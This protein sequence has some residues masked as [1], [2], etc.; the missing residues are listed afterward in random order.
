M[1]LLDNLEQRLDRIVNGSFSKAFKSEVQPVELGAALQQEIDN[2]ADTITGQTVVPNIFIIELGS[3]DHE[4]LE[5]YFE[6]L[7]VELGNLADAYSSEQ[8]YTTVD[9]AHISFDLDS[10][11]ETGVFR[12]RSTAAK[13]P[14]DVIAASLVAQDVTPQVP[15]TSFTPEAT[16][17]L[18]S[19]TGEEFKIT[20]SVTNIG[21]GVEAD[22]QIDD[23]SVSRLHCAIVLGSE[24]LV[25]D[26][27]STNGTV[28]D[29]A[30]ATESI[31]RDG[32]IIKVGNITLTYMSK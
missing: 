12:I 6:T 15:L 8:R 29:G 23:T 31:L 26:L 7:S 22:I 2:R 16:P 13:R 14:A 1:G 21:R 32:S 27:G 17:Y 25:R 19:I 18:T 10:E 4:R 5:T 30:R 3:V 24:V 28:V 20:K 11:L 9:S